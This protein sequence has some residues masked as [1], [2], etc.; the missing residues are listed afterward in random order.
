MVKCTHGT[1]QRVPI[2]ITVDGANKAIEKYSSSSSSSLQD[3]KRQPYHV[4]SHCEPGG[5]ACG[6]MFYESLAN[7]Y[8]NNQKCDVIF[9]HIP[10]RYEQISYERT[11][12]TVLAIIESAMAALTNRKPQSIEETRFEWA[13]EP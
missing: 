11:R 9:V 2:D 10:P 6:L 3:P 7:C 5:H 12:D 4:K 8:V 13:R 1:S